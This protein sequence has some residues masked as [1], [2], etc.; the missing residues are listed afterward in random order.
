VSRTPTPRRPGATNHPNRVIGDEA[1]V[2]LYP[3]KRGGRAVPDRSQPPRIGVACADADHLAPPPA[4]SDELRSGVELDSPRGT[5]VV[6]KTTQ[7]YG[8]SVRES[9]GVRTRPERPG[10]HG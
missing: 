9:R 10:Q 8:D 1:L 7:E 2:E 4:F 6:Q 3:L 5:N